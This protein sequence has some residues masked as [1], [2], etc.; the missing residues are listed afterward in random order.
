MV[1]FIFSQLHYAKMSPVKG[2]LFTEQNCIHFNFFAEVVFVAQV[3]RMLPGIAG[4]I[5]NDNE[6]VSLALNSHT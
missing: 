4:I 5:K 1:T 2:V 3:Y 6:R